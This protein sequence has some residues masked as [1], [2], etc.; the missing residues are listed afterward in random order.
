MG[1]LLAYKGDNVMESLHKLENIVE[2]WLK[3]LPHLPTDWRK[4]LSENAWW[5]NL[6]GVVLSVFAIFALFSAITAV[7]TLVGIYGLGG[8]YA[9]ATHGSLWTASMYIS[10]AF[11][12][13]TT[14]ITAMAITPLRQMKKRGWDLVFL[15]AIASL[16]S[17][18]VVSV[19]NVEIVSVLS[20]LIGAAIGVYF[21]FELRPYFKS[22][23]ADKKE[24]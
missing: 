13:V 5:I 20:Q 6:I 22:S 7:S 24:K 1:L 17:G 21:L 19:L 14:A 3:P 15:A 16:L 8:Y 18:L 4:W 9:A 23:R 10:I 12:A 2:E 11:M